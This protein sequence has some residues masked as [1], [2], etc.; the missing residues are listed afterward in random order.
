MIHQTCDFELDNKESR[1]IKRL[2]LKT[3]TR[4]ELL[5]L[6]LMFFYL[7]G[8]AYSLPVCWFIVL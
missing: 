7:R 4:Q 1:V 6:L 8:G 3:L 5:F 2:G